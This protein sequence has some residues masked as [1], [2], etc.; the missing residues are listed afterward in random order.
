MNLELK[1]ETE[2]YEFMNFWLEVKLAPLV[3]NGLLLNPHAKLKSSWYS[4]SSRGKKTGSKFDNC[5]IA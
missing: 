1:L 3:L 2:I 4:V 5:T